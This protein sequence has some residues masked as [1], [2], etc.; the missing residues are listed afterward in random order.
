[1]SVFV[2]DAMNNYLKYCLCSY[3]VYYINS[4][5]KPILPLSLFFNFEWLKAEL[6]KLFQFKSIFLKLF[7]CRE[8]YSVLDLALTIFC[9]RNWS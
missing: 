4:V 6:N 8:V 5:I 7:D 9:F 1:M 2:N 3:K